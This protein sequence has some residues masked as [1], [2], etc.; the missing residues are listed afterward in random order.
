MKRRR[1]IMAVYVSLPSSHRGLLHES[2]AAGP[3][4]PSEEASI[5]VRVRPAQDPKKLEK[6]VYELA[7]TPLAERKYLTHQELEAQ[8]G[9]MKEDLD[10]I[11]HY[12][13]QH[14]LTVT[15]RS[16]VER[17]VVL[18][19]Q[20]GDILA[21]FPANVQM[22]HSA[23]GT[24]RG[25]TGT[26]DVPQDLANVVTAVIGLDTRPKHRAPHR[27]KHGIA[28]RGGPGGANGVPAT[29]FSRRYQFPT[30]ANGVALDGNGQTVAIVELGG[31]YRSSD[32]RAFFNEINAPLPKVSSVS[33]DHGNNRPG[34]DADGEVM[35]D[36]EVAG[37]VAPKANFVIYFGPN[38]NQGFVDAISAAVHDTQRKPSVVSISWGAP[39]SADD[40][41]S[42]D[43]YHE[44]FVAAAALGVTVCAASGDHGTADLDGTHWDS[45]VHVDHPA[46]DD[47][48]LGC[49]GTQ[50]DGDREPDVAWNDGTPFPSGG[51]AGGGGISQIFAVPPYQTHLTMPVPVVPGG[52]SGRGVPDIAMS[53][54]NYFTRVDTQEGAS[55]G[56]SAVAPLMASLIA[57]LNQ[58]TGKPVG[59]LNPFLYE[60]GDKG[61]FTDVVNGTNG[62][63]NGPP[64]YSAVRGWDPVT[65]LG[66]PVGT[67]ILENL[68]PAVG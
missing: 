44:V 54:T 31:G 36:I 43:A 27:R 28:V 48:V 39:E 64:G 10:L 61:L 34:D 26:I 7:R 14:N 50:I 67:A 66:T 12:A 38:T 32:L 59:F 63:E 1:V 45:Q 47:M 4:D 3:I 23:R 2:R 60:N 18:R 53:A 37:A 15:H 6:L 62:I 42:I 41:Q 57:L 8:Y 20:L 5:T 33:V 25:R 11:E 21:L 52:K 19:G 17:G 30:E 40:Q 68:T 35:L 22:Y 13:Q 58:A 51:W 46:C 9:A 24:Y 16:A 56:T 29:T 65:G 55:G 49:G